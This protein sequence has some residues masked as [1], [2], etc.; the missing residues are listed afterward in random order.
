MLL[1]I[2]RLRFA[3]LQISLDFSVLLFQITHLLF[4]KI[5][6]KIWKGPTTL[7][8]INFYSRTR[9]RSI[10]FIS[11]VVFCFVIILDTVNYVYI[12]VLTSGEL[13]CK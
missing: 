3:N 11:S 12:H 5:V 2:Q 10:A 13:P 7:H 9:V 6:N 1:F 4:V 8:L